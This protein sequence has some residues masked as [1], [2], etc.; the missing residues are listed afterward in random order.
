MSTLSKSKKSYKFSNDEPSSPDIRQRRSR[1]YKFDFN[2]EQKQE[3]PFPRKM[4]NDSFNKTSDSLNKISMKDERSPKKEALTQL[5][6]SS[7]V[8]SKQIALQYE[9]TV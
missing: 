2:E 4:N 1:K 5:Q 7:T 6:N 9:S 3:E 8:P